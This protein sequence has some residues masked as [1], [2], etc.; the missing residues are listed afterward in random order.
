LADARI[1]QLNRGNQN[2]GESRKE[3]QRPLK[4][5]A[6]ARSAQALDHPESGRGQSQRIAEFHPVG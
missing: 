2:D 5:R 3:D 6:R 4:S 1:G